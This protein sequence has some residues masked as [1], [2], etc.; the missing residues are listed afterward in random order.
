M[1]R[2][3]R[4]MCCQREALGR[5]CCWLL[6][7][8][9]RVCHAQLSSMCVQETSPTPPT[10]ADRVVHGLVARGLSSL[11]SNH[12]AQ[13]T[14]RNLNRLEPRESAGGGACGACGA[15][16]SAQR[17]QRAHRSATS[18]MSHDPVRGGFPHQDFKSH[19]GG[20]R[21]APLPFSRRTPQSTRHHTTPSRPPILIAATPP[22][23]HCI[24]DA[25]VDGSAQPSAREPSS[26]PPPSPR[27]VS[28]T[29]ALS[30]T[31]TSPSSAT[32]RPP[33]NLSSSRSP[34]RK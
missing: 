28:S 12:Y 16:G 32:Y 8:R 10:P 21:R 9:R 7:S 14:A 22:S 4:T 18:L 1:R 31:S 33:A 29:T 5:S 13:I 11:E 15:L 30:I 34:T 20:G 3:V 23:H 27:P 25:H 24:S 19:H 6:N 17:A 2:M 26:A